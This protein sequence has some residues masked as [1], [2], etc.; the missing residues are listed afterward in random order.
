MLGK[1]FGRLACLSALLL[2]VAGTSAAMTAAPSMLDL[3]RALRDAVKRAD[4]VASDRARLHQDMVKTMN[5]HDMSAYIAMENREAQLA[6]ANLQSLAA[7]RRARQTLTEAVNDYVEQ[8]EA[9]EHAATRAAAGEVVPSV[10]DLLVCDGADCTPV[11]DDEH[12]ALILIGAVGP[13]F[14][15]A[16]WPPEDAPSPVTVRA[17]TPRALPLAT[18]HH[19]TTD[20]ADRAQ[21]AAVRADAAK[22]EMNREPGNTGFA[23]NYA[24]ALADADAAQAA[25]A[26]AETKTQHALHEFANEGRAL[27]RAALLAVDGYALKAGGGKVCNP[28]TCIAAEGLE[29]AAFLVIGAAEDINGGLKSF[30]SFVAAADGRVVFR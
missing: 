15:P 18:L 2:G 4:T 1:A 30:G 6:I 28:S 23:E 14:D 20:A 22:A 24:R 26:A 19:D 21:A 17:Y 8:G 5:R 29:A 3:E 25:W 27:K 16:Q 12:A 11:S 10:R 9:L 13:T 7:V